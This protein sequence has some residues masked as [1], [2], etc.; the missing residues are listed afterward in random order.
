MCIHF[1][2]CLLLSCSLEPIQSLLYT[3]LHAKPVYAWTAAVLACR[4]RS[5][6]FSSALC[7]SSTSSATC[8]LCCSIELLE[9]LSY[10][11][12]HAQSVDTMY[13]SALMCKERHCFL[14]RGL[15]CSVNS[16]S[17]CSLIAALSSL[18][19]SS[20]HY[21]ACRT[22]HGMICSCACVERNIA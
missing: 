19:T 22:F 10:T 21:P 1:C 15:I 2:L 9:A 7:C 3:V 11:S 16:G 20:P 4:R 6:F 18:E 5:C 8:F 12:L 17:T 13:T 14:V